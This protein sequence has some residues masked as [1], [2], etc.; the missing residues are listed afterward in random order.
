M[1]Y[2]LTLPMRDQHRVTDTMHLILCRASLSIADHSKSVSRTGRPGSMEASEAEALRQLT[3]RVCENVSSY[4]GL[5]LE[6]AARWRFVG[7]E[8]RAAGD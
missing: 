4:V 2:T 1:W 7:G 8:G 5:Q 3:Q 6:G